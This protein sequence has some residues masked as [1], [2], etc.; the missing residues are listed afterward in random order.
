MS[1]TSQDNGKEGSVYQNDTP[2]CARGSIF[3]GR[4][5]NFGAILERVFIYVG[6]P[7][8]G[9]NGGDSKAAPPHPAYVR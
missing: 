5:K 3:M 6:S 1:A 2:R 8:R 4:G 9:E 7:A